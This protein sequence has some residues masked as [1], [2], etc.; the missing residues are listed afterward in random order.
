MALPAGFL[1]ELR[2]RTPL[3]ALVG[4][5]VKLVRSGRQ[6]KGCCP[7]HNEKTPSFYVYD[8]GYHCFGCGAHGDAITFVMQ[9]TGAGFMDAV[10]VLA[11]EAG[12]EVPQP[13]PQAAEAERRRHDLAAVLEAAQAV[14]ARWLQTPAGAP[15]L[16]YLRGRGLEDETIRRFGLG[17]SG[18]G[19]GALAAELARDGITPDVLLEAG[20]L[21][22]SED[23]PPRAFF[24]NRV[25]FPIRDGRGRVISFG[26][27]I[28]GD[29]QPKYVNG[30]ETAVFSKR[31]SLYGLDL[32]HEAVR[33]KEELLVVEGYMDVISLHQAGLSGAVAPL[34]TA[35]TEEHLET[36]WK[37]SPAPVLCFDGDEAGRRA[38]RRTAEVA[39]PGLA[40]DRML[41]LVTLPAGEDPDSYVR[42]HGA[43][44]FRTQVAAAPGLSDVLYGLIRDATGDATLE[45]RAALRD[46]LIEAAGR[47]RDRSLAGEYR[48]ALLDRFFAER[49]RSPRMG[50]PRP[51]A[52]HGPR[53]DQRA[54]WAAPRPAPAA[55]AATAERARILT[56]ILLNHPGLLADVDEAYGRLQLPPA[57]DRLRQAVLQWAAACHA[58]DT[59]VLDSARVDSA[60][61]IT[62]LHHS[63]L[64]AEVAMA[65]SSVP[66]PLPACARTDAMPAE[67]LSGW[68]HIF[69]FMEPDELEEEVAAARR[70][71][72]AMADGPTQDRLTRLC[73]ARDALRRGEQGIGPD[74]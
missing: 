24:F 1:D 4:R 36:L 32:A 57:L 71:F 23:G 10:G 73:Q 3:A 74:D 63:G 69:G 27:R 47:I 59:S 61:L 25:I 65:L 33:Q 54:A 26:G 56:A 45:Q 42:R 66:V 64:V 53:R 12:L 20:L 21:R 18:D 31:R 37:L 58:L 19:R 15:A 50:S 5:R 41:K 11:G 43:A 30:P 22:E 48:S 49:P 40:A 8:D 67:A 28:L 70:A 44:A 68:W 72:E 55:G 13:S 6:W 14:F 38:A 2:A 29:G 51:G 9:T 46:R 52:P 7:F 39:L 17:W 35:L 16:G 34:G 60:G 62:H